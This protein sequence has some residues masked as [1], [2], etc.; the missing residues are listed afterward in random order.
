MII[1]T[2]FTSKANSSYLSPA[3]GSRVARFKGCK[4]QK[5]FIN[6]LKTIELSIYSLYL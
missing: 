6:I 5:E 4:L 1:H 2:K 3:T